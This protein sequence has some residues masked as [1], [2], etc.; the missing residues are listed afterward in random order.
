MVFASWSLLCAVDEE[1]VVAIS[2]LRL[3]YIWRVCEPVP[4]LHDILPMTFLF[5]ALTKL[6]PSFPTVGTLVYIILAPVL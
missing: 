4:I 1:L 5:N 6:E 3:V 2:Y